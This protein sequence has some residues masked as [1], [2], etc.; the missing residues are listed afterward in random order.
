[1]GFGAHY[2]FYGTL[3][4]GMPNYVLFQGSLRYIETCYLSGYKMYEAKEGYPYSIPSFDKNDVITVELMEVL[5]SETE[6][7][8]HQLEINAG[9][10]LENVFIRDRKFGIYL[11][12]QNISHDP[13]IP[14]GDWAK[15]VASG[16]F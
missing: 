14:H 1:M 7:L 16:G 10:F 9:Y 6:K 2:A 4:K 15:Y 13:L 11:Y 5:N 8:I 12:S 3:R